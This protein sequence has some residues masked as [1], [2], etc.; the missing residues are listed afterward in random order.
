MAAVL[1]PALGTASTVTYTGSWVTS[2]AAAASLFATHNSPAYADLANAFAHDPEP[3]LPERPLVVLGALRR[4]ALQGRATDPHTGDVEA[5]RRDVRRL[6]EEI[7]EAAEASLVQYTDPVRMGDVLP[8]MWLAARWYPGRPVRIVEFGASA[9]MLLLSESMTIQFA[10]GVWNPP[11]ALGVIDYPMPVPPELMTTPL[12]IE[13]AVGI[14]VRPLD[15]RD[16]NHVELLRSFSWPGSAVRAERLELGVQIAQER[17]PPLIEGD[18]VEIAPEI[19]RERLDREAVT[20]VI[21][22]A[23][24]HYLPV[25]SRVSLGRTLD[26]LCFRGPLVLISRG[27]ADS[28]DPGRSSIRAIDLTGRRRKVYAEMNII[29]ESPVWIG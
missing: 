19:L 1:S 10:N 15:M 11:G 29:S 21:D 7:T 28:R 24:S 18:V 22:S 4:A 3:H 6:I 27:P 23:F 5:A 16:P 2:W 14:D 20:V 26:A 17:P 9:G 25:T 12:D 13:S 8:G